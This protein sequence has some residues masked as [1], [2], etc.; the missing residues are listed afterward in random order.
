MITLKQ[1]NDRIRNNTERLMTVAA[2]DMVSNVEEWL[3]KNVRVLKAMALMPDIV[4][5]EKGKQ[6]PTLKAIA[7]E[8][9][10]M[11]LVFTIG[12]NGMNVARNDDKPLL[13]YADRDYYKEII[14]GGKDLSWQTLVG[15]TSK[16]PALVMAVPIK[17]E[18]HL[19][20]ALAMAATIEDLS[21]LVAAW[22]YGKTGFAFLIDEK[23]KVVSHQNEDYVVK[24]AD[25]SS[26][27]LI[28]A[29]KKGQ[30][31]IIYFNEDGIPRVG[32]A[33]ETRYRWTLA[34]Q[35]DVQETFKT[36]RETRNFT[37]ILFGMTVLIVCFVALF[38]GRAIGNPIKKLT[39]IAERI[40]VGDLGA[41]IKVKSKDEIGELAEAISRMQDSLRLAVEKLRRR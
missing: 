37:Y 20:G 11:Y 26:S 5:M 36:L 31:G 17:R 33:K 40:S 15:K 3:D 2:T 19:I 21:K 30:K 1:S 14:F 12:L 27:P 29:F 23:G 24:Q 13:D 39:E 16:K 34:M 32:Y 41:T 22:R 38:L 28:A 25:M 35:Q 10:W 18:G 9:P 6:E 8:Y 7:Q 4:G